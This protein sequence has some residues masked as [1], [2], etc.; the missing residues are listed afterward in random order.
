MIDV[1]KIINGTKSKGTVDMYVRYWEQYIEFCGSEDDALKSEMLAAWRQHMVNN[2]E[3]SSGTINSKISAIKS[4]VSSLSERKTVSRETKWDFLEVKSL[5]SVALQERKRPNNRI[6]ITTEQM[7]SIVDTPEASLYEPLFCLHRAL[8]LL[9]GTTGMRVSE[10]LRVKVN[11]IDKSGSGHVIRNVMSK[12]KTE[13]RTVPLGAEAYDA[14]MDWIHI[15]PVQSDYVFISSN[16]TK[17]ELPDSILWND[18]PM[19]RVSAWRVVRRYGKKNGLP[20]IKPH[21]L[22]RFVGTQLASK[23]GIRVA[24]KVLGHASPDTTARYYILDDTPIGATDELF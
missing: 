21:D 4:I 5:P 8:L 7:R 20:N 6:R 15:R 2:T 11:D 17:S 1:F 22:R 12:A 3:Y 19:T 24:Q 23:S 10:A 13:P 9:L 18:E 14:V 16:R